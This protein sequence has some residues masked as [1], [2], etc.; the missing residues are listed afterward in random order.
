MCV[1]WGRFHQHLSNSYTRRSQKCNR[2]WWLDYL[3]ALLGSAHVKSAH[4]MLLK[5]SPGLNFINILCTAFTRGD[6]KSVER[7]W[8]LDWVLTL[9]G[10]MGIKAAH[11]MLLKLSPDRRGKWGRLRGSWTSRFFGGCN[12]ESFWVFSGFHSSLSLPM[13]E[14]RLKIR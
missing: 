2:H 3:F 14:V 1:N 7:Y 9:W 12:G 5:L 8:W 10:A 6:P 13:P 4:K 11:K